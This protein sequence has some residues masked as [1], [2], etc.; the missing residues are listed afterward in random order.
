M[1][2]DPR[3]KKAA[4]LKTAELLFTGT[5]LQD[6]KTRIENMVYRFY[7]LNYCLTD[8]WEKCSSLASYFI[9]YCDATKGK[10]PF[11]KVSDNVSNLF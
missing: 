8:I 2:G 3:T 1:E 11:V 9:Q 10:N 7:I 4:E 6:E 5:R